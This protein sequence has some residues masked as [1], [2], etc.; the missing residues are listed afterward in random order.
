MKKYHHFMQIEYIKQQGCISLWQNIRKT[1]I[2]S[3]HSFVK[4]I[5][6]LC[7]NFLRLNAIFI[8]L[9]LSFIN[10]QFTRANNFNFYSANIHLDTKGNIVESKLFTHRTEIPMCRVWISG[11]LEIYPC[12]SSVIRT[13]AR[14]IS[15]RL[16][17]ISGS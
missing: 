17:W 7:S 1:K 6:F 8:K 3:Q 10:T 13:Y 11:N 15:M 9:I 12:Y 14:K 5:L 16:V 4:L 2:L